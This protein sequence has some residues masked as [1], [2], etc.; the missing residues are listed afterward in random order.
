MSPVVRTERRGHVAVVRL[1]APPLNLIGRAMIAALRQAFETLAMDPPRAAVL[2]CAGGGADVRELAALDR[3]TARAFITS[4][5]EACSAIRALDAP[6]IA[7]IDG[8][9]MGAHLEIAAACDLR[10]CSPTSRFA[11][12]EIKVGIPSVIDA[13]WLVAVCGVGEAGRLVYGGE[14]IDAVEALRIHL[15]NR[16]AADLQRD[17]LGW[18]ERI[19]ASSP[20]ALAEQKRV[21]RAWT[22]AWYREAV[23]ASIDRFEATFEHGEATEAMRAFLEKRAPRF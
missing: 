21:M 2:H 6:V 15:V 4:L 9:C 22:E 19:A 8:P 11:M 20:V 1:D 18:A 12:P 14:P 13:C 17:A 23:R 5:H 7:A 10:I 3:S 16:I